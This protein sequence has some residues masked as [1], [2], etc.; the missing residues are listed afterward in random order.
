[1][2]NEL[3]QQPKVVIK[4]PPRPP[5]ERA[6]V[7]PRRPLRSPFEVSEATA[8]TQKAIE[9]IRSA[10]RN[11]WADSSGSGAA[12]PLPELEKSLKQL[13]TK[14]EERER[15]LQDLEAR[16][17]D[18][19]RNLAE[20]ETLLKARESLLEAAKMKKTT[21]GDSRQLSKEE[22][23]AL[24]QLKAEVERQQQSLE[25]QREALHEREAFL[26][27]SESK[28][29]EKVQ[30]QQEKE[31]ELEQREEDLVKREQRL[32]ER[33]AANDPKL[34][35]ALAADKAARKKFSDFNE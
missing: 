17:A 9:A 3:P 28:L 6:L 32:L 7:L 24:E 14:L 25:Q 19:E 1:M 11:P 18:R 29:F 20:M 8:E 30:Q 2:S 13:A 22:Q 34:A 21:G 16:L 31:T 23:N 4:F 10:T 26:D 5:T 33:E 12:N 35:A 15:F 27:D